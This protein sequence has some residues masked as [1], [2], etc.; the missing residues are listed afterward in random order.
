MKAKNQQ[1]KNYQAEALTT[2]QDRAMDLDYLIPGIVGEVGE[3]FG[4]RAK[5]HWQEWSA[6]RLQDEI[7]AEYGDIAWMTAVLLHKYDADGLPD[8]DWMSASNVWSSKVD[9]WLAVH[10]RAES[11]FLFFSEG[12]EQLLLPGA[13]RLWAALEFRAQAIT[14]APFEA[15]LDA[16][17]AKLA[18]RADKGT[19]QTHERGKA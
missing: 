15:A 19:L 17:L 1:L 12:Q 9:P 3:L 10:T 2:L 5:A 18:A 7:I 6:A 14:G 11:L 8:E 4:Q 16:N 13:R